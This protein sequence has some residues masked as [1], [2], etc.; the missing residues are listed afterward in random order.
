MLIK[1][2]LASN[3]ECLFQTLSVKDTDSDELIS[4]PTELL[5]AILETDL[6]TLFKASQICRFWQL[7]A[8]PAREKMLALKA[9]FRLVNSFNPLPNHDFLD[10]PL[11]AVR[12]SFELD[13]SDGELGLEFEASSHELVAPR[14][15]LEAPIHELVAP[16]LELEAPRIE[17]EGSPLLKPP[18]LMFHK[19][20]PISVLLQIDYLRKFIQNR[21][22]SRF[23]LELKDLALKTNPAFADYV[24][25][26]L[27]E[28]EAE[29]ILASIT[30]I[31]R[32]FRNIHRRAIRPVRLRRETTICCIQT[33]LRKNPYDYYI[34]NLALSNII[35]V[36]Q[37]L[38]S[39]SVWDP[40]VQSNS[41]FIPFGYIGL[42]F[43]AG[44]EQYLEPVYTTVLSQLNA[45]CS[46][47]KTETPKVLD[48]LKVTQ[49]A[50]PE[51]VEVF[52]QLESLIG[53]KQ[54][55]PA[56]TKIA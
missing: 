18:L 46:L 20:S 32:E 6:E 39:V 24:C 23:K 34:S 44:L 14:P 51:L 42:F 38:S 35:R 43:R 45:I 28:A 16:R 17:L 13:D 40:V 5:V 55:I 15:A 8:K 3:K 52:Q 31:R 33:P 30:K 29:A 53:F 54:T 22:K 7:A 19:N 37:S 27:F 12:S 4:L 41:G 49:G 47:A 48:M 56:A 25:K 21:D 36:K 9:S 2:I 1:K 50:I 11:S 10:Q 26:C